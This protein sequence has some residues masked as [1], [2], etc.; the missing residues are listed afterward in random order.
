LRR[1]AEED[2][3]QQRSGRSLESISREEG[4]PEET[5]IRVANQWSRGRKARIAKNQVCALFRFPLPVNWR[6]ERWVM[7]LWNLWACDS[8]WSPS[9]ANLPCLRPFFFFFCTQLLL[10]PHLIPC[11]QA[12]AA[13]A[14]GRLRLK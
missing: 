6:V 8:S 4:G 13:S 7:A 2:R 10:C 14:S 12:R 9:H 3:N 1:W 5:P 11:A